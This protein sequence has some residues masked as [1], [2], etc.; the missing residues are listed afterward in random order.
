MVQNNSRVAIESM[1]LDL[2][3]FDTD[4]GIL[5]RLITEMGPVRAAKTVVRAFIVDIDCH[6][7]G[8]VLFNDVTACTGRARHLRRWARPVVAGQDGAALQVGR[9]THARAEAPLGFDE[10]PCAARRVSPLSVLDRHGPVKHGGV[11]RHR[12]REPLEVRKQMLASLL[13]S[14]LPGLQFNAH[15]THPGDVVFA[16]A[17]KMGLEGIVSKRLGLTYRSGHSPDWLK[18]RTRRHRR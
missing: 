7:L 11:P 2:V 8:A 16:H 1:K 4:G 14:S 17:C 13:R 3:G 15:L 6:Q 5:R 10:D 18:F 9:P 12:A